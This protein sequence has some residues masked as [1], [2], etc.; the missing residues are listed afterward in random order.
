MTANA[1]E[2]AGGVC[3][4]HLDVIVPPFQLEKLAGRVKTAHQPAA[5]LTAF[6]SDDDCFPRRHVV[7]KRQGLSAGLIGNG[8]NTRSSRRLCAGD[9]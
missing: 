3:V 5:H 8:K 4:G 9:L 2:H 7:V 1:A 6:R